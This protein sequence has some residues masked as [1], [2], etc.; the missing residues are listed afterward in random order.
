MRRT[1]WSKIVPTTVRKRQVHSAPSL[2]I[3][4]KFR[5]VHTWEADRHN[6][7]P[8]L[9]E[10]FCHHTIILVLQ[11]PRVFNKRPSSWSLATFGSARSGVGLEQAC[12]FIDSSRCGPNCLHMLILYWTSLSTVCADRSGLGVWSICSRE[13]PN[14][15]LQPLFAFLLGLSLPITDFDQFFSLTFQHFP[16]AIVLFKFS[17]QYELPTNHHRASLRSPRLRIS[18]TIPP[19]LQDTHNQRFTSAPRSV[20]T[21]DQVHTTVDKTLCNACL[22]RL[23]ACG[24]RFLI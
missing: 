15:L 23:A 4:S 8:F 6:N 2:L 20:F 16:K 10:L 21:Q 24:P 5:L 22:R 18:S 9:V 12:K 1:R 11:I 17:S 7:L 14:P 3:R 19:H 13:I